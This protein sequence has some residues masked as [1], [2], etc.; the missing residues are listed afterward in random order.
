[1]KKKANNRNRKSECD[2]MR[3]GYDFSAGVRGAT[4]ARYGQGVNLPVNQS[5][6]ARAGSAPAT[7]SRN[8]GRSASD[9]EAPALDHKPE[10]ISPLPTLPQQSQ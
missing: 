3:T 9:F 1:M 6:D 7:P 5:G 2:T 8:K 4:A 10:K